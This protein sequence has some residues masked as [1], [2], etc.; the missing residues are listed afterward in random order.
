M[1]YYE[2]TVPAFGGVDNIPTHMDASGTTAGDVYTA[3]I[4]FSSDPDVATITVPVTMIILGDPLTPPDDLEAELINDV[5]G[6]VQLTWTHTPSRAFQYFLIRRDSD[7]VGTTTNLTYID[8]LPDYGNYCYTVQAVYDEGQ[9][10]PAG[11]ECIEWPNPV[12][13]VDPDNLEGWV[14][15]DH[16]V[17]VFTTINNIGIGT[18]SYT[19]PDYAP[20][21]FV[22]QHEII[23]HDDFGDGWNDGMLTVYLNGIPVLTDITLAGG[24]GPESVYFMANGGDEITS[25]FV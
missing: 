3:D 25:T 18:L 4:V 19:F 12:L 24:T 23:M 15:T 9:T 13:F 6:E 5:T 1:D 16:Q 21:D 10:A 7:I 20:S 11:P 14:W 17:T 2:G 8:L 22:C